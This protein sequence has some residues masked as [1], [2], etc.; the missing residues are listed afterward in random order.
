MKQGGLWLVVACAMLI[1]LPVQAQTEGDRGAHQL[2]ERYQ[3]DLAWERLQ[4]FLQNTDA[5]LPSRP[6]HMLPTSADTVRAWIASHAKNPPEEA[7]S[8]RDRFVLED[9]RLI[10]RFERNWFK[11]EHG[12]GP[13][14]YLGYTRSHGLVPLDTTRT[15]ELRAKLQSYFGDPSATVVETG[16]ESASNGPPQFEY[17]FIVNDSIPVRIRDFNGPE[18]R[19]LIMMVDQQ[20][21]DQLPELREQLLGPILEVEPETYVDYY[22]SATEG[23]WYRTGYDGAR[24]FVERIRRPNLGRGRPTL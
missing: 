17:A 11:Q 21:R 12:E 20:W 3:Q 6:V 9:W 1:A 4:E 13:W 7:E 8:E 16:A 19:G 14:S 15:R 5:M 23:L 18:D 10:R 2:I 22:Y 24:Y